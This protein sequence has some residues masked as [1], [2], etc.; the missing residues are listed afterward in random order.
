[1]PFLFSF[2]LPRAQRAAAGEQFA[3]AGA[4]N[5]GKYRPFREGYTCSCRGLTRMWH[6]MCAL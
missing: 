6:A 2:L 1:M 4:A 5:S 3:M